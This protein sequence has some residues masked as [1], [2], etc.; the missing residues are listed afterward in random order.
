MKKVRSAV[1]VS[2]LIFLFSLAIVS[3]TQHGS[4]TMKEGGMGKTTD[5]MN[6]EKMGSGME[7]PMDKM[8][9]EK[10][11]EGMGKDMQTGTK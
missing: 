7:K 3:C 4:D 10:M 5:S 1:I 2:C 9:S 11:D 8:N 6:Q